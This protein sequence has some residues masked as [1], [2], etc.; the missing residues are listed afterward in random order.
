MQL[1]FGSKKL[2]C[3]RAAVVAI[4]NVTPDSYFDGGKH[5]DLRDLL[6]HAKAAL[7]SGADILEIGGESTG[8]LS[9][10]VSSDEEL[11]RV[12]PALEALR[13]A[14]P[15]AWIA[16]DTVKAGVADTALR[17]GADMINDV[18]AGRF[19]P[20]M[21]SVIARFGCPYVM[22]YSKDPTP[23]TTRED[24][25]YDDVIAVIKNF[26]QERITQA[27][28]AGVPAEQIIVDPGLGHF[29]SSDPKYSFEILDRL[30]ELS[31]LGPVFVSPSRKSFLAGPKNL[32][33]KDRLPATLEA[34]VRAVKNGASFIRTH[35]PRETS[36]A[37]FGSAM[38]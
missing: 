11:R 33:P 28:A 30:P 6:S 27:I 25:H 22:M 13:K 20:E 37:I 29:V 31:D 9:K 19:D 24:R 10:D 32:P 7:E 15:K 34:S 16:I 8:P 2:E 14:F 12:L 1:H 35:D 4:L 36:A 21:F 3:S 17:A 26:L 5:T 38:V 18:S 23:R